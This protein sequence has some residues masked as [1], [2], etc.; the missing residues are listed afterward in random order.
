ML[1][2][3]ISLFLFFAMSSVS[4]GQDSLAFDKDTGAFVS[5]SKGELLKVVPLGISFISGE[6]EMK[7]KLGSL[8]LDFQRRKEP[9]PF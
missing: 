1:R 4:K 9:L 7:E 3:C 5:R 2:W 6:L 8:H